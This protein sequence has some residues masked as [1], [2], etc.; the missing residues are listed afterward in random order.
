MLLVAVAI[1]VIHKKWSASATLTANS[2]RQ[3]I[4]FLGLPL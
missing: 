1:R 3:P 2:N 4:A